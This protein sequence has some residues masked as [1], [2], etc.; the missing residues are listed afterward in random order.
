M[1]KTQNFSGAFAHFVVHAP[2]HP[3]FLNFRTRLLSLLMG[4]SQAVT[5]YDLLNLNFELIKSIFVPLS[6]NYSKI[7]D[8][9]PMPVAT[10]LVLGVDP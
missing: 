6:K 2:Q 1:G 9:F 4:Y 7:H 3:H 5:T 8:E 10:R